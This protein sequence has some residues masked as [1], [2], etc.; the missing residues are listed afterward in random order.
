[1][2]TENFWTI[3]KIYQVKIYKE[4]IFSKFEVHENLNIVCSIKSTVMATHLRK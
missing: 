2:Y 3:L 4:A 1:M